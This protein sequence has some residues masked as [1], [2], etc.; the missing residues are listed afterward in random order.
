MRYK[1]D[2][3]FAISNHEPFA[4]WW[5]AVLLTGLAVLIQQAALAPSFAQTVSYSE[6][7]QTVVASYT[8]AIG[9]LEDA[10]PGPS[11]HV[12]GNGRARVHR[13]HYMQ[14]AGDF[15]TKLSKS[16]MDGLMASLV[17]NGVLDFDPAAV[18][19]AKQ[20]ARL[21]RGRGGAEVLSETTDPS[22]MTIELRVL[23][24]SAGGG[25]AAAGTA[26]VSKT[27]KWVG[28]ES[29]AEHFPD[30]AALRK[31]NAAQQQMRAV[32]ERSDLVPENR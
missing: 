6:D 28:L 1:R 8:L 32:M 23:R 16:E 2:S 21:N 9:E 29:D 10:D 27:V 14:N 31:L 5:R 17:A 25:G 20:D 13:P 24:N 30:V 3:S 4:L 15:T 22:V 26:V 11:V 18:Q 7:P 12:Y 19:K